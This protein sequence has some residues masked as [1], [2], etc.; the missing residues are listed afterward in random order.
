MSVKKIASG[1]KR[2]QVKK[3]VK[4]AKTPIFRNRVMKSMDNLRGGPKFNLKNRAGIIQMNR[5]SKKEKLKQLQ[6]TQL[7]QKFLLNHFLWL[8]RV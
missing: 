5:H 1:W 7:R 2:G 8:T 6:K 4:A 3:V